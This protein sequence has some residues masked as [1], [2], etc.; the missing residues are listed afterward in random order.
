MPKV[1]VKEFAKHRKIT[2][3]SVSRYITTGVIP[4]AAKTKVNNRIQ[5]DQEMADAHIDANITPRRIL[6]AGGG[7]AKSTAP[8]PENA[9]DIIGAPKAH[10][11]LSYTDARAWAQRY[12][13]ALLKVELEEKQGKLIDAEAVKA[14]AFNKGRMLRDSLLNIPDRMA[15]ILAAE[16]DQI[17]IADIL[18]AEIRAAL[19]ELSGGKHA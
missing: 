10:G 16:S 12:K 2:E 1:S 5:I 7:V 13:A 19:D 17:K 14:A 9:A 6:L 4:A 18:A 8:L 15:A 11:G 3:Q